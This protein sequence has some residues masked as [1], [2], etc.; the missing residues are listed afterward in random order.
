MWGINGANSFFAEKCGAKR[1]LALDVYPAT[2][3]FL[4][5]HSRSNS[6]IDFV[7]GDI[8]EADTATASWYQQRRTLFWSALPYA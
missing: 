1:V 7:L 8:N 5:E 4:S 2:E 6:Q 3:Q